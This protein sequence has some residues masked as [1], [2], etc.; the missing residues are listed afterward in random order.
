[1]QEPRNLQEISEATHSILSQI[2]PAPL[3]LFHV[4]EEVTLKGGRFRIDSLGDRYMLL[5]S[6]P[7]LP[8]PSG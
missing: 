5:R 8:N 7:A 1:M 4:G 3:P 2:K 6:L